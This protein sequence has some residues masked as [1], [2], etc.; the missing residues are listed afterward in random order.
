MK[1][2]IVGVIEVDIGRLPFW[3]EVSIVAVFTVC[4]VLVWVRRRRSVED[5]DYVAVE[6]L[7]L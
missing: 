1:V 2:C 3:I 5:V 6:R 7:V 4:F